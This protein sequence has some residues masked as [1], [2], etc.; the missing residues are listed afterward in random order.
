MAENTFYKWKSKYAGMQVREV[1]R[2]KELEEE[3]GK[4]KKL[5][6][7]AMLDNDALK[8]LLSKNF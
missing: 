8:G 3:N 2:L 5:L 7:D 1:K 6:A 4:L